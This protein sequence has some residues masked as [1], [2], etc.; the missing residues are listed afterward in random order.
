MF[1]TAILVGAQ[2]VH[3]EH[4][5][6]YDGTE[7]LLGDDVSLEDERCAVCDEPFIFDEEEGE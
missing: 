2:L 7:R 6:A 3:A 1:C 5:D 4:I